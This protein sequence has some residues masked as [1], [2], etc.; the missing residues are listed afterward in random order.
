MMRYN[1]QLIFS[2]FFNTEYNEHN[3]NNIDY[4]FKF[5][6][7]YRTSDLDDLNIDESNNERNKV[8]KV[9]FGREEP[10]TIMEFFQHHRT[11]F[12]YLLN[13]VNLLADVCMERNN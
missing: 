12:S 10:C 5:K 9:I 11:K 13:Y 8:I 6:V 1:Q 2:H 3:L 7:E 4:T